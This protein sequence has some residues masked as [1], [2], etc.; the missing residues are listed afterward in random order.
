[1]TNASGEVTQNGGLVSGCILSFNEAGFGQGV[2]SVKNGT[3]EV[4][5]IRNRR[6]GLGST[7]IHFDN[8]ILR[9]GLGTL[10]DFFTGVGLAEIQA[11]GLRLDATTVMD[12]TIG[13]SLS[14]VGSLTKS[15][16][17]TATLTG[18][19][20]YRGQHGRRSRQTRA[21]HHPDEWKR[22][23]GGQWRFDGPHPHGPGGQPDG[24]EP[25]LC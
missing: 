14:G 6:L 10:S 15:G 9:T 20:T 18:V 16:G 8:A 3:L 4:N 13:Q 24:R 19:N 21:A 7:A 23:P 11:G 12:V 1:M 2:Y 22:S 25:E 17:T 5:Q